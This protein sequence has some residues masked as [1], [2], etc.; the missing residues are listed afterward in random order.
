MGE[1]PAAVREQGDPPA[2]VLALALGVTPPFIANEDWAALLESAARERCLALAWARSGSVIRDNAPPQVSNAWRAQ[3]LLTDLRGRQ[4]LSALDR[5]LLILADRNIRPIV[6]KGLPLSQRLYGDPFVRPS[7]DT[8][9]YV[10]DHARGTVHAALID[11]GYFHEYGEA[12]WEGAYSIV[13]ED[14][15]SIVEIHSSLT[16]DNLVAHLRLGEPTAE[17]LT[18]EGRP[19]LALHG[20]VLPVY[21]AAHLAKHQRPPLQWSVDFHTLWTSLGDAEHEAERRTA[22]DA[23]GRRMLEWDVCHVTRTIARSRWRQE[24]D[25]AIT[26]D[27]HPPREMH[28]AVRVALLSDG[29]GDA[30]RVFAGWAF[31]RSARRHIWRAASA[32]A[33]RLARKPLTRLLHGWERAIPM[34][35]ATPVGR[36]PKHAVPGEALPL[37]RGQLG[38]AVRDVLRVSPHVWL[39][40]RGGSMHPAIPHEA[41]VRLSH[42][43]ARSVSRGAVVLAELPGRRYVL[44]RVA[45]EKGGS[46]LLWGDTMATSDPPV[47]RSRVIAVADT[48]AV[49][50]STKPVGRR[51]ETGIHR[52]ARK[53]VR[54]WDATRCLPRLDAVGARIGVIAGI[55]LI[56]HG[57]PDPTGASSWLRGWTDTPVLDDPLHLFHHVGAL[58]T[59]DLRQRIEARVVRETYSVDPRGEIAVRFG[60]WTADGAD[61]LLRTQ[62]PGFA[63][64]LW[65]RGWADAAGAQWRLQRTAFMYALASRGR[66]VMAHAAAFVLPDGRGVLCPG[67]SGTGKSTLASHL[68]ADESASVVVLSDDRVAVTQGVD[69]SAMRIWGTPWPSSAHLASSGGAPLGGVVLIRHGTGAPRVRP[70]AVSDVLPSL[71]RALAWPFWSERAME[72]VLETLD[73][74]LRGATLLEY[75]YCPGPGAAR[76]LLRAL[77]TGSS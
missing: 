33:R 1:A 72:T 32:A 47:P 24:G 48:I 12:P 4:R 18:I 20:A 14:R 45:G 11:A 53:A 44:H 40:A 28:N 43:V 63:Y 64:D 56:H 22:T 39:R 71:L 68:A 21:L 55:P 27:R 26:D 54:A 59:T 38:D 34:A 70:L 41:L 36:L 15:L 19:V 10:P 77:M 49:G 66:G 76:P 69:R 7:A 61:Q 67:V 17:T 9:L 6:L 52:R 31:P 46:V 16:D 75:S 62:M 65:Y 37:D 5:I 73:V 74:A 30:L 35:Y 13:E 8:D 50:A 42:P 58:P 25:P 57:L 2:S 29:P 3:A 23:G 60:S 51:A